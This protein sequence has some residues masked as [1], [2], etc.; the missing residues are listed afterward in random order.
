MVGSVDFSNKNHVEFTYGDKY[1]VRIGDAAYTEHKFAMFVSVLAQ[2]LPGDV[3][4]IDLSDANTAHF[5]PN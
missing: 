3:G 5:I 1:T 4:I 2:L